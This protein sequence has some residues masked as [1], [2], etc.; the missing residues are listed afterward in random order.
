MQYHNMLKQKHEMEQKAASEQA[1]KKKAIEEKA[2]AVKQA[3]KAVEQ[4]Q[5]ALA[6]LDVLLA[7][8]AIY[9]DDAARAQTLMRERGTL[10]KKLEDLETAWLLAADDYEQAATET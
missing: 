7:D 8:P 1:A 5:T 6:K 4:A 2:N 9:T 10:T 3:E